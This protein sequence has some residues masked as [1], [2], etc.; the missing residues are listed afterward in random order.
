[1]LAEFTRRGIAKMLELCPAIE[2]IQVRMNLES[3]LEDQSFFKDV[4]VGAIKDSGREVAIDIRNW[5]LQPETLENFLQ[6]IPRPRVS[7]KYFAEH[8]GM[9]YQPVET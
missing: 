1:M 7:F 6:D 4:V 3:G 9:P 2:G 8:M 5:G